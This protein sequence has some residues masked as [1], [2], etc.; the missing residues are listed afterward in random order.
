MTFFPTHMRILSVVG[1]SEAMLRWVM[2]GDR[3]LLL[4]SGM[5]VSDM[6]GFLL[7]LS[8]SLLSFPVPGAKILHIN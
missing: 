5:M 3:V 7:I 2:D 4:V 8:A 1:E 6:C